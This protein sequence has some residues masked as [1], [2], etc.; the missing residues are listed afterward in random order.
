MAERITQSIVEQWLTLVSGT[1]RVSDIWEEIGIQ[2]PENKKHLRTILNRI[3]DTGL[4]VKA[5]YRLYRKVDQETRLIDWQSADPDKTVPL[6]LPFDIHEYCKIYPKSIIIVTANKNEG[7]TAF[8][9]ESIKLNMDKFIIDLYNTETG[10]EQM[11]ERFAP[12]NIPE[13]A[14]FNV[15]ERYDSFADVI[16]PEHLSIIDY[17]DFNSEVYLVGAE[18]DAIFRKKTTG[19]AIIAIQKPPPV[20][21]YVKGKRTVYSRDLAYGGGFSAKRAVLYITMGENKLKLLYVKTPRNPKINPN[22][23]QWSYAFNGNGYFCNIQRYFGEKV[24]GY[25]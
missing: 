16:H 18:I 17:L 8:L 3:E 4:I 14:P 21:T 6:Q 24:E 10:P 11:K 7:K 9:Y 13:P 2:T 23:M 25:E 12:L 19:V 22:N 1:F 20:I 5:G 15:Y